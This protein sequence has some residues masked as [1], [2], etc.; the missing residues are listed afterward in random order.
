MESEQQIVVGT[1]MLRERLA[2][3]CLVEHATERHAIDVRRLGADADDLA[4]EVIHHNHDPIALEHNGL[5]LE[6]IDTPQ[7]VVRVSQ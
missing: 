3:Y 4:C 5:T 1:E 2:G 6:Q 7:A